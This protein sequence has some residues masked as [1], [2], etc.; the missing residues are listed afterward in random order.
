[1][2]RMEAKEEYT[3]ALKEGLREYKECTQKGIPGNPLVLDEIL[4]EDSSE[5]CV[6]VGLIDI[7]I[8][9][10]VGTKT[11][12]RVTAFTPSF[13]P[14]LEPETEFAAKWISLCTAHLGEEGI[15]TPIEC[16][17]YLGDFYVQ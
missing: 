5:N 4:E 6:S 14:L 17:E 8:Q 11:A 7:P 2:S 9:R 13:R 12:G 16:F 10:I 15:Q 1:M 3:K